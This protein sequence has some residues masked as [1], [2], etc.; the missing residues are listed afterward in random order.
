MDYTENKCILC[1]NTVGWS[2]DGSKYNSVPN[3]IKKDQAGFGNPP[4]NKELFPCITLFFK[5]PILYINVK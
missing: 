4:V 3:I 1:F 5:T 2:V